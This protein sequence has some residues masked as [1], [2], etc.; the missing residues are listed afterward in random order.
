MNTSYN[1]TITNEI[2]THFENILNSINTI[3]NMDTISPARKNLAELRANSATSFV[4]QHIDELEKMLQMFEDKQWSLSELSQ[5]DRH[6]IMS[7]CQYLIQ[8]DDV[9]PDN[10][11]NIGL[12]D[13]CIIIDIA[14][15]KTQKQLD[16][17]HDFKHTKAVYAKDDD[18]NV[19][20]WRKTKQQE[21]FSRIR[22]RRN[23]R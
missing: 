19:N 23:K 12:L 17:Y 7:A 10:I 20:D 6:Y 4:L 18:F 8:E 1:L 3:N 2:N 14:S 16:N 11:P 13:D 9:I 21:K 5:A 15:K 22:N